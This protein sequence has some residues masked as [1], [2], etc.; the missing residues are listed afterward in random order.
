MK[1]IKFP[2]VGPRY[3]ADL[4]IG[5][6]QAK[7]LYSLKGVTGKPGEPI[8]R[9]TPLGWTCIGRLEIKTDTGQ[10]NFTFL[11]NQDFHELNNPVRRFWDIEEPKEIQIVKQEKKLTEITLA[12][13]QT[14]EDD[15]NSVSSL[16][17]TK[18]HKLPNNFE[19]AFDRLQNRDKR[20]QKSPDLAKAYT[21]VLQTH[22]DKEYIHKVS[23]DEEKPNQT[24]YLPHFPVL[25]PDKSTTK[26]GFVFDAFAKY[27]DVSL[28]EVLLQFFSRDPV[29]LMCDITEIFLQI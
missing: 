29:A 8:A 19:M 3:I 21:D 7:L 20:L 22:C 1:S 23:P 9:L 11:V 12:E 13:T 26:T 10:T 2:R 16:R 5:V 6:D 27:E 4:L 18:D 17:K 25:R 14:L 15:C 28:N 24:W